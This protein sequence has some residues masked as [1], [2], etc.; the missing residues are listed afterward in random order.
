P[1]DLS[2]SGKAPRCPFNAAWSRPPLDRPPSR[3]APFGTMRELPCPFPNADPIAPPFVTR[4][5]LPRL[6]RSA[7]EDDPNSLLREYAR[8][9]DLRV[10]DRLVQQ[11][12]RMV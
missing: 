9:R 6:R 4:E 2:P 12:E 8:T 7:L 1:A 3:P 10:R 5:P 11:H